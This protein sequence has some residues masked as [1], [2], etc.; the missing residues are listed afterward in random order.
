MGVELAHTLA[1]ARLR[2][3]LPGMGAVTWSGL[4]HK[5]TSWTFALVRGLFV[6]GGLTVMGYFN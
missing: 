2:P 5:R 6:E 4:F 1:L 3:A